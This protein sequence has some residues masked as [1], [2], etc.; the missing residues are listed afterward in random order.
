MENK[1]VVTGMGVVSPLGNDVD[2]FWDSLVA[3]RSG[4]RA[5]EH[6]DTEGLASRIAGMADRDDF[7]WTLH[8]VF[9]NRSTHRE[10]FD[11]AFHVFWRN[12]RPTC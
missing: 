6:I 11:Q 3:G 9:V 8:A 2:S 12:P 5:I 7:Y 1:V 4:I 10:L